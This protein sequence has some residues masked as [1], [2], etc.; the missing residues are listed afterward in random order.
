MLRFVFEALLLSVEFRA[1][2]YQAIA[3]V[4]LHRLEIERC[5]KKTSTLRYGYIASQVEHRHFGV[6]SRGL[7]SIRVFIRFLLAEL[8][9]ASAF[10]PLTS[11]LG[12]NSVDSSL[13]KCKTKKNY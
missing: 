8:S 13:E 7:V 10:A 5:I 1:A 12:G 3:Q 9:G 4:E 11:R 6:S 2:F